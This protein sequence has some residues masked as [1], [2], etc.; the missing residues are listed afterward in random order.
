[1]AVQV[2]GGAA[3]HDPLQPPVVGLA[4]LGGGVVRQAQRHLLA[5]EQQLAVGHLGTREA[6]GQRVRLASALSADG[7][8]RG[9][10]CFKIG[11]GYLTRPLVVF[12]AVPDFWVSQSERKQVK[13]DAVCLS[14]LKL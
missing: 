8:A 1:M 12:K 6:T 9:P 2:L 14:G 11:G 7:L 5:P 13:P 10:E 4:A 3:G